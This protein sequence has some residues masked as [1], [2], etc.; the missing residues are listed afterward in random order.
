[1]FPK[2][3]FRTFC[4]TRSTQRRATFLY[5]FAGRKHWALILLMVTFGQELK[6]E[7]TMRRWSDFTSFQGRNCC[8]TSG[9]QEKYNVK[10]PID[11]WSQNWQW[12]Q[13]KAVPP[14][15]PPASKVTEV[16][17]IPKAHLHDYPSMWDRR[18]RSEHIPSPF[19]YALCQ[20]SVQK[21]IWRRA[22]FAYLWVDVLL[23]GDWKSEATQDK[24]VKL[25]FCNASHWVE[26]AYGRSA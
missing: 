22:P 7:I 4:T 19:F 16:R 15:P 8:I 1:M 11:Y 6:L 14:P 3:S 20:N 25:G 23:C 12:R 17:K 10:A 13:R 2:R 24:V 9:F 26:D 18:L 21:I 5:C